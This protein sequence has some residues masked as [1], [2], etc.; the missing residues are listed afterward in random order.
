MTLI[1][2][3]QAKNHLGPTGTPVRATSP[4]CSWPTTPRRTL[5]LTVQLVLISATDNVSWHTA[6]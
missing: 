1:G 2:L 4:N 5:G 3:L 6:R